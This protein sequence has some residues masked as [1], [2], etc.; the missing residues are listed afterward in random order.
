MKLERMDDFFAAR[1]DG[2]DEH[3]RTTIEGASAFYAY[4]AS[5]LPL[6]NGIRVALFG[7]GQMEFSM[8]G[9]GSAAVFTAYR[10]GAIDGLLEQEAAGRIVMIRAAS[11][12]R[13]GAA[14]SGTAARRRRLPRPGS[15]SP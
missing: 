6:E 9:T 13:R 11:R 15:S 2:Y 8:G 4:T 5:L 3:M 7:R 10:I 12:E 1:V 14:S